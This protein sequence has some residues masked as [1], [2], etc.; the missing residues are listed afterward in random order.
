M[1]IIMSAT[2][3]ALPRSSP[4]WTWLRRAGLIVSMM[5]LTAMM[6]LGGAGQVKDPLVMVAL[7][8]TYLFINTLFVLMVVTGK[9][10]R[11]RSILFVAMAVLF[12]VSFIANLIEVRGSMA[13][14]QEDMLQGKTP[15]CHMVIPMTLIPAALTRTIIFPGSLLEGFASIASMIVIW[16]GVSLALGRGF[17]SW[18]CFFGGMDEGFSKI[19]RKPV[20]RKIAGYWTYFPYALLGVVALWSAATLA[21]QYC[22]WF[23]PFK[24]VTEFEA[25]TT[26]TAAIQAGIFVSL[27]AG[28]VVV[29]PTLTKRRIQCGLF[30]PMGAFQSF[31][32]KVNV[33]DVRIAKDACNQ[34]QKC[35]R[36][37]PTF[38]LDDQSLESGKPKMSCMKCGKCVD[39]CPKGAITYHVKGTP[40]GSR[41][42]AARMLFVFPAF[43]FLATFGG[44]M[45]IDGIH[46][47]LLLVTTGRMIH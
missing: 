13:L 5:L 12:V 29:L 45:I 15:F 36:A 20:I 23:C 41:P 46:R 43:L 21:P 16:L 31:T 33:F 14:T 4:V 32:N 37:C 38:S 22:A 28:L 24:T 39:N 30:C 18:G 11:Y 17:C 9:T 40:C 3:D 10:D 19:L 1:E 35:V 42:K 26:T 27:F 6:L 7:G 25:V 34:C 44:G 47:I 8:L 2:M